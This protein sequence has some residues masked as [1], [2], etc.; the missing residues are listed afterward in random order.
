MTESQTLS[1]R[2]A[3]KPQIPWRQKSK[4][5]KNQI[6]NKDL[7]RDWIESK[8]LAILMRLDV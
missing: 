3:A 7:R 8:L 6:T 5:H 1:A 2:E 4:L